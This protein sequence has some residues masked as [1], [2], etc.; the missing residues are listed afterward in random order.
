MKP[1]TFM[2]FPKEFLRFSESPFEFPVEKVEDLY[3]FNISDYNYLID[4]YGEIENIE[5]EKKKNKK[6]LIQ[7]DDSFFYDFVRLFYGSRHSPS[8]IIAIA[9]YASQI[10]LI[11]GNYIAFLDT[12]YL[13]KYG[14][15]DISYL[16]SQLL[17][18]NDER[19]ERTVD[20]IL[21][22]DFAYSLKS[23]S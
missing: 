19:Y 22:G 10:F 14:C 11:D 7:C 18:F 12:F 16:R 1:F 3:L 20:L 2:N 15:T 23:L 8:L 21:S 9:K 17:Y 4:H 13:D 6:N 5:N